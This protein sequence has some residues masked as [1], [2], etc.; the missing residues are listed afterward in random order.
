MADQVW[1][2]LFNS[3]ATPMYYWNELKARREAARIGAKPP[4]LVD[5]PEGQPVN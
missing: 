2:V 5:R 1:C 3:G 4:L